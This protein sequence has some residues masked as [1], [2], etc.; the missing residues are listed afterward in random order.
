LLV[1]RVNCGRPDGISDALRAG[2]NPFLRDSQGRT[3][4]DYLNTTNCGRHPTRNP[5]N[6]FMTITGSGCGTLNKDDF[7]KAAQILKKAMRTRR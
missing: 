1:Q 5:S 3:A 7:R 4:L 6:E 2:A